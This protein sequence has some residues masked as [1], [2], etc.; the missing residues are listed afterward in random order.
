[1]SNVQEEDS[2]AFHPEPLAPHALDELLASDALPRELEVRLNDEA[3]TQALE[4]ARSEPAYH[5]LPLRVYLEGKGCDGFYYGVSFADRI[6]GD[7][8]FAHQGLDVVVDRDSFRFLMGAV[9]TWID[10]ER[11]RGFLVVN[12]HHKRFRGKFFKRKAWQD[13]LTPKGSALVP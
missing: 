8:T 9:V 7:L 13:A 10:D 1:M 5:G 3:L 4:L 11:G 6:D 2:P 12:P